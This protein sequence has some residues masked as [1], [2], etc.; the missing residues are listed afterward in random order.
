V[1]FQEKIK[2]LYS[3]RQNLNKYLKSGEL[4]LRENEFHEN[5]LQQ[6]FFRFENFNELMN[7][8]ENDSKSSSIAT[9]TILFYISQM[10][11]DHHQERAH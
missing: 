2:F 8:I 4:V 5:E 7:L 1:N 11:E 10:S 3:R 6:I 9:D